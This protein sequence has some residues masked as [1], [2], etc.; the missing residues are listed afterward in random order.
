MPRYSRVFALLLLA[1]LVAR[2]DDPT[3]ARKVVDRAIEA[4]GGAGKLKDL[5]GGVWKT[6]GLVR[7]NPSKAEFS[8]ELPG[9]FRIDSTRVVDGQKVRHSRIVNGDKGWVVEGEKVTPMTEAEI[10][11]VRASFYH[12]QAA[13]T[14]VPLTD[15]GV[16]LSVAGKPTVD[17]AP[18]TQI[19]VVRKGFPDLLLAFD[20]KTGLLVKSEMTDKDGRTQADRKVE[21]EWREYKEFDG[22]KMASKTK[23]FHDGKLFIDTEITEFKR[24]TGLPESTFTPNTK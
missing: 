15:K 20:D 17:G 2:A 19:K 14:L 16:E 18:A 23:T 13:T 6:N 24:A 7:G 1:P 5:T 3:E 21:I 12:K 4:A 10:A 11:G 8:G 22:V 9:K